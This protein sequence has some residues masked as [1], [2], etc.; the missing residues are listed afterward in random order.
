MLNKISQ[1]NPPILTE[2]FR[3]INFALA[4]Y[5]DRHRLY[6]II[7]KEQKFQG[8]KNSPMIAEGK[9]KKKNESFLQAIISGCTVFLINRK[10]N[11]VMTCDI[12]FSLS[13]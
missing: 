3:G 8:K 5:K 4:V 12:L 9:K 1:S 13:I 11:I 10:F 6:V 7:N 2:M